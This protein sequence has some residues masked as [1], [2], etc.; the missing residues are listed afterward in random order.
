M[1]IKDVLILTTSLHSVKMDKPF[2]GA[3]WV[4]LI[5]ENGERRRGTITYRPQCSC[6]FLLSVWTHFLSEDKQ[7]SNH[8]F[9][10]H[11][12]WSGEERLSA[13]HNNRVAHTVHLWAS[14][15]LESCQFGGERRPW[16]SENRPLWGPS[17][18]LRGHRSPRI[19]NNKSMGSFVI[20]F[21][22]KQVFWGG[23]I[24][25]S[26]PN[27]PI[28]LGSP[29]GPPRQ[30]AGWGGVKAGGKKAL[31]LP[32]LTHFFPRVLSPFLA[33]L[34]STRT[35]TRSA[36]RASRLFP[37]SEFVPSSHL[38]TTPPT[39]LSCGAFVIQRREEE[40]EEREEE[41]RFYCSALMVFC[42]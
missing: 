39:L 41:N 25:F 37:F 4:Y 18:T 35:N 38:S 3:S 23:E 12:T 42:V 8:D 7:S 27:E 32:F 40:E 16:T 34:L 22:R 9:V 2:Q 6:H 30:R 28:N 33:H 21:G 11:L 36:S 15:C 13:W 14:G 5:S 24:H 29:L 1:H 19:V 26:N 10:C 20:C 17:C 31:R